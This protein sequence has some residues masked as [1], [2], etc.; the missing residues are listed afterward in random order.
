VRA[1]VRA[2]MCCVCV[3]CLYTVWHLHTAFCD[4]LCVTVSTHTHVVQLLCGTFNIA[5]CQSSRTCSVTA[6]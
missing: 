3:L 1:C 2:C 5:R 4:E 6:T